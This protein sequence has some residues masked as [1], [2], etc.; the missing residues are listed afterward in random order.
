MLQLDPSYLILSA[1]NADI[2]PQ[3]TALVTIYKLI[4]TSFYTEKL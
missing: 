2:G 4:S 3:N 1:R